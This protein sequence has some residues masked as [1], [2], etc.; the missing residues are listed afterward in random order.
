[1][2]IWTV[3]RI[4]PLLLAV[5]FC[6]E[7]KAQDVNCTEVLQRA[8]TR[9]ANGDLTGLESNKDFQ[10]CFRNDGYSDAERIRAR[11]LVALV[12]IYEDEI[13]LA[14]DAM[15]QLLD[16]DPEHPY[17]ETLDPHEFIYLYSKFRTKPIFRYGFKIGATYSLVNVIDEF[18]TENLL[19]NLGGGFT[20]QMGF[21]GVVY[22]DYNFWNNFE[23]SLGAGIST[24]SV[25][26]E[27]DL[28]N[29]QTLDPN[30]TL[31]S[32]TRYTDTYT[33]ID[34]PLV[35]KYN[36][37]ISP[38]IVIYPFIGVS[39]HYLLGAGRTGSREV[40]TPG[41]VKLDDLGMREELNYSY[42]GGVGFKLRNKTN[43][44][45]LELGANMGGNN[46]VDPN[47]RYQ[48]N[49]LVFRLGQVDSNQS[50]NYFTATLGYQISKYN[51]K[52][53][54]EYRNK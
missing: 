4:L 24:R 48:S 38:K 19:D 18:G 15:I 51:P 25:K 20:G 34:V 30:D 33:F 35:I 17:D 32:V 14:E 49:D 2:K 37:N 36:F 16:D 23:V 52:K 53:L 41:S 44:I 6:V 40:A 9:Y 42:T 26:Y 47:G 46:F 21:G 45:T 11:K 3:I 29:Q 8:D 27:N 5:F 54:K 39:G 7:T 43:Y 12:H 1:M 50:I 31:F 10:E 28:F 22:I 13:P